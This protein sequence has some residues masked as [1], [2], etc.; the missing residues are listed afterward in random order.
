MGKND[1][2]ALIPFN[3][4]QILDY[5][6]NLKSFDLV[7]DVL[8]FTEPVDSSNITPDHWIELGEIIEKHYD[9]FDGFIVL[10]GTDTMAYT[11]SAASFMLENLAKPVIFTGAQLPITA[12]RSDAIENLITSIEIASARKENGE[13]LVSEVCIF[14]NHNLIR[15]NRAQ[16]VEN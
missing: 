12:R 1:D 10:H 11:A 8:A 13:M 6:P 15:G 3:F 5:I 2:G 14:F 7:I 16:K 4:G 9:E